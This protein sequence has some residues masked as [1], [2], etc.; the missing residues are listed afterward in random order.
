MQRLHR[1][2]NIFHAAERLAP[3]T[4]RGDELRVLTFQSGFVHGDPG[5]VDLLSV[6]VSQLIVAR[7]V[8][9]TVA[10]VAERRPLR[11]LAV[12]GQSD[13]TQRPTRHGHGNADIHRRLHL[14]VIRPLDHIQIL[15]DFAGYIE[16]RIHAMAG[17]VPKQIVFPVARLPFQVDVRPSIEATLHHQVI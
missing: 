9:P 4:N 3:L 6:T 7:D 14:W 2:K 13:A 8:G 5:R 15:R 12:E 16:R 11:T 17:V 1:V 10:N